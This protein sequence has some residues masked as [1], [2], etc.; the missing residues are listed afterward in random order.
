ML[1]LLADGTGV[2]LDVVPSAAAP[3]WSLSLSNSAFAPELV[4]VSAALGGFAVLVARAFLAVVSLA[5]LVVRALLVTCWVAV[6]GAAAAGTRDT[7]AHSESTERSVTFTAG[8]VVLALGTAVATCEGKRGC[9]E[10][11][12]I[13]G[14]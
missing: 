11:R 9:A 13:E 1:G 7:T 5:A 8:R 6:E 14:S 12:L 3:S 10:V 4:R 2:D